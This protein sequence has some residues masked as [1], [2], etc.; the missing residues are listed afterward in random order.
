METTDWEVLFSMADAKMNPVAAS[1][2]VQMPIF[3]EADR[4]MERRSIWSLSPMRVAGGNSCS[5]ILVDGRVAL[6]WEHM[7]QLLQYLKASADI[8]GQYQPW[9]LSMTYGWLKCPAKSCV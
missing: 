5:G 1:T 4:G 9:S 6:A 7:S 8:C 3:P 2:A